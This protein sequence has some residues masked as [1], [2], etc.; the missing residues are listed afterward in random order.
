MGVVPTEARCKLHH[1]LNK[2]KEFFPEIV[3]Q[4]EINVPI[5][6]TFFNRSE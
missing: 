5:I 4:I 3:W 1:Y 6:L 2:D